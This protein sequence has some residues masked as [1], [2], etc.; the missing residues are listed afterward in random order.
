MNHPPI[1]LE[2]FELIRLI[3]SGAT[4]RVWLA[5]HRASGEDSPQIAVKLLSNQHAKKPGWVNAFGRE[6]RAIASLD[7]PNVATIFDHG[8]VPIGSPAFTEHGIEP[9][10][11]YLAME[12][13]G[14][15]TLT[16]RAGRLDWVD[17]KAILLTILDALA[18]AHA[19]GV[20]H[21]DIKPSNLMLGPAG[22]TVTDFGL[23]YVLAEKNPNAERMLGTPAY[24]APEQFECRW[25]DF[26]PATDLYSL[27]CTAYALTCAK[28][29]FGARRSLNECMHDHL[30]APLPVLSNYRAVPEGFQDWI[31][32]LMR[33]APNERFRWA[34]DA[35]WALDKL[36]LAEDDKPSESSGPD[37]AELEALTSLV[38]THIP[39]S[40]HS[41]GNEELVIGPDDPTVSDRPALVSDAPDQE[42]FSCAPP[43]PVHWR[44]P[45]DVGSA[46]RIQGVGLGVYGLRSIALV[47]REEE[48]TQLWAAL[49]EVHRS[50]GVRVRV[51]SGDGGTGKSR[52]ARWL[53]E[54][55]QESG[56]A[57][58]LKATH[59]QSKGPAD[60]LG[61]MASRH[62]N[63]GDMNREEVLGRLR[64]IHPG[65]SSQTE[66]Q[67][68]ALTDLLRPLSAPG[69]G[70]STPLPRAQSPAERN[71]V[72]ERLI[73][74][75]ARDRP[76][77]LWL[78][79][80]HWDI[81]SL[82]FVL[83]LLSRRTEVE[84]PVLVLMT[85]RPD[86]LV[87]REA[88]S[89]LLGQILELEESR[90]LEIA[91]FSEEDRPA[92][93]RE[94]LGLEGDLA[95][96]VQERTA[97]NPLFAVQ[98]VGDWV[99][100][101]LLLPTAR[102]FE[103]QPGASLHLPDTVHE[104]WNDRIERLLPG[105]DAPEGEALELAAMLGQRLDWTEWQAACLLRGLTA[106]PEL[107]EELVRWRLAEQPRS[108][109]AGSGWA[110]VHG[111]LRESLKRRA[112]ERGRAEDLHRV[113][114]VI[115]EERD[116][117]EAGARRSH[118]L[119]AAGELEAAVSC[120]DE[121]AADLIERGD[122]RRASGLLDDRDQALDR[123]GISEVGEDRLRG[124]LLRSYIDRAE[125]H[126][127]RCVERARA[128]EAAARREGL[129]SIL[130]DAL[131]TRGI[132]ERNL[133]RL[134]DSIVTLGQAVETA[135]TTGD[136][137]C[138][139][140]SLRGRGLALTSLAEYKAS[141]ADLEEALELFRQI[142]DRYGIGSGLLGLARLAAA[143]ND[144]E[145]VQRLA[146][147]GLRT[148]DRVRIPSLTAG[149]FN[150]LGEAARGLGDF[151]A[152]DRHYAEAAALARQLN[153]RW[154][155]I[156]EL[157]RAMVLLEMGKWD[158]S[159]ALLLEV[160]K[161]LPAEQSM[162]PRT[163]V[164]T[165]LLPCLA[166]SERWDEWSTEFE[167]AKAGLTASGLID[168]DMARMA[169]R[170]ALIAIDAG[171]RKSEARRALGLARIQWLA[172]EMSDEVQQVDRLLAE[173]EA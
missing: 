169:Y 27:G 104:V 32:R 63:C 152:A 153:D 35:A 11:P 163:L 49:R 89:E 158:E 128:I 40:Y 137:Q 54:R 143:R 107:V 71:G 81:D 112:W 135:R 85:S 144:F 160:Q 148:T 120:L 140:D 118:H 96:R 39:A 116:G 139:A 113:C 42:P 23:G 48:R 76:V 15:G 161:S 156:I 3:G 33:K 51:L 82:F 45:Q 68:L 167:V 30:F 83:H 166:R 90:E 26:G 172:L 59:S 168:L 86:L 149:F 108:P 12:F 2:A 106:S 124:H 133:G 70:E 41:E 151:E 88:E 36:E 122:L 95:E 125:K 10:S 74:K 62:L 16:S 154:I 19:R 8:H 28:P 57:A 119:L 87:E 13:L 123:L 44:R 171:D 91:P 94:I 52:L 134:E 136:L 138:L 22:V 66:A 9:G 53:C 75:L 142:G 18:H 165:C 132:A 55:A 31:H 69:G 103:L 29:P 67:V 46:P 93:I 20:L 101:G 100:R 155:G 147:E 47:G 38:P 170:S 80:V 14:G 77:I 102:G 162:V 65:N 17:L 109:G 78:D 141:K 21:R 72:L 37:E 121:T 115:L 110:F 1:P 131:R 130:V 145:E 64:S 92:L 73:R 159:T 5:S 43:C 173:L 105:P 34:A 79:D 97:G 117:P 6:V 164:S 4:G 56:A 146:E 61:A 84:L 98:L 114:A 7:H 157:N 126:F 58:V 24:M 111:M 50:K 25:R 60:G 129:S 99:Q 150:Q 127:D